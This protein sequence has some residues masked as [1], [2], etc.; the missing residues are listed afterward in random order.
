MEERARRHP[1]TLQRMW[2][3]CREAAEGPRRFIRYVL[4]LEVPVDL[5]LQAEH[6]RARGPQARPASV[7]SSLYSK[8]LNRSGAN[9]SRWVKVAF[10]GYSQPRL[11]TLL[12]KFR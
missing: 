4:F 1:L 3:A 6:T 10:A 12:S 8:S 5:C 9:A 7:P 2:I 11:L